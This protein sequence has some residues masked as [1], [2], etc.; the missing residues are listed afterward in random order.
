[1]RTEEEWKNKVYAKVVAEFSPRLQKDIAEIPYRLKDIPKFGSYY[2]HGGTKSGKTL[3]AAHMYI[4]AIK[5][6]YLEILPGSYMFVSAYD[7]FADLKRAFDNPAF[8]EEEIMSKYTTAAYLVLDDIGSTKFTDWNIS[9]LQILV[10]TRYEMLL[11]TVFTSNLSLPEL[12][13]AMGDERTPSRIK[14][15]CDKII[16]KV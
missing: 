2:I 15:M 6:R 1:M 5:K 13:E 10:N 7:F 16:N 3:L 12:E 8:R 14:R 9:M 4:Q 11:P